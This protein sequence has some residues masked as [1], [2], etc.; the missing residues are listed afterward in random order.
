MVRHKDQPTSVKAEM[1]GKS[2]EDSDLMRN[3]YNGKKII[4]LSF[5]VKK[6]LF[7]HVSVQ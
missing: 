4:I 1:L 5:K 2:D 3:Y 6:Q 7:F